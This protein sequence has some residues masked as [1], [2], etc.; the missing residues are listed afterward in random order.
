MNMKEELTT[1]YLEDQ[2]DSWLYE[3]KGSFKQYVQTCQ[4]LEVE[5]RYRPQIE[6]EVMTQYEITQEEYAECIS[7]TWWAYQQANPDW[8]CTPLDIYDDVYTAEPLATM[9][10]AEEQ[11]FNDYLKEESEACREATKYND[12][13]TV[14]YDRITQNKRSEEKCELLKRKCDEAYDKMCDYSERSSEAMDK[15]RAMLE[16]AG[17]NW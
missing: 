15:A 12:T 2:R 17:V 8:N 9:T 10:T 11:Q 6:Q 1:S 7:N 14:L 16:K 13:C 3:R 4:W 5:E